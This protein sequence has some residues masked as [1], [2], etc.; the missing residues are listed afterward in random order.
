[1]AQQDGIVV[2]NPGL[3]RFMQMPQEVHD[4]IF[5]DVD[6]VSRSNF[7]EGI[8]FLSYAAAASDWKC[9]IFFGAQNEVHSKLAQFIS[10]ERY[11][12]NDFREFIR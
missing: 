7:M 1:M 2:T 12:P 11:H 9:V 6:S 8:R 4:M 3:N 5:S 10:N